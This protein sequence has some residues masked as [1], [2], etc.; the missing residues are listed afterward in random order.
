MELPAQ[1]AGLLLPAGHYPRYSEDL[2]VC[3]RNTVTQLEAAAIR[4][5]FNRGGES[6]AAVELRW[7]FPARTDPDSI[8]S[9]DPEATCPRRFPG[10]TP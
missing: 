7:R 6:A 2:P 5:A 8:Q 9:G 10:V 1:R 3:A 4:A